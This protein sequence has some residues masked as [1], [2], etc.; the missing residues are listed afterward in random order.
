MRAPTPML[1]APSL[2]QPPVE[3]IPP[4]IAIEAPEMHVP[5]RDRLVPVLPTPPVGGVAAPCRRRRGGEGGRR[6]TPRM[7]VAG[8]SQR[9]EA[10]RA[11]RQC[12]R[13]A[14]CLARPPGRVWQPAVCFLS[15]VAVDA[16]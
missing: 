3:F 4:N 13:H 6:H 8:A 7:P 1:F 15:V 10:Q 5:Q 9:R 11:R 2:A 14:A 12:G 16:I